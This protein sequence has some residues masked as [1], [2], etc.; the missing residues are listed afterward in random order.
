MRYKISPIVI[1]N[2]PSHPVLMLSK[3]FALMKS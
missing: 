2:Q 3:V 1:Q